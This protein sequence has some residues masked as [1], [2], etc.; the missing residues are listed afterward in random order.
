RE[1]DRVGGARRRA[2][3]R[4]IAAAGI[5]GQGGANAGVSGGGIARVAH[6]R[7]RVRLI[8]DLHVEGGRTDADRQSTGSDNAGG[9]LRILG[10]AQSGRSRELPDAH[11]IAS[12]RGLGGGRGG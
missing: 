7:K 12:G 3:Q 9:T 1:S 10:R 8:G 5:A 11:V 6:C 4:Q 2:S